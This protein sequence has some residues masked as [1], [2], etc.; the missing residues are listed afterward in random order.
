MPGGFENATAS[1][2]GWFISPEV[3]YGYRIPVKSVLVTPRLRVRYVGGEL[4]GFSETGCKRANIRRSPIERKVLFVASSC[5]TLTL[6]IAAIGYEVL[7]NLATVR[8]ITTSWGDKGARSIMP[9]APAF[10]HLIA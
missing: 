10:A 6:L 5:C 7:P 1:Y 4:D 9:S 3:T 8:V 2:G